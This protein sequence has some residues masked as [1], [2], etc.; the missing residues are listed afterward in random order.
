[1][2]TIA[3]VH[4]TRYQYYH[5]SQYLS[6]VASILDVNMKISTKEVRSVHS[7]AGLLFCLNLNINL[8]QGV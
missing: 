5:Q 3:S 1:M 8:S 7:M 2:V 6:Q 4:A